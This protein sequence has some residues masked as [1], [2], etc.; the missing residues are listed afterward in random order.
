M[1][2]VFFHI[3]YSPEIDKYISCGFATDTD[4]VSTPWPQNEEIIKRSY[5]GHT[6]NYQTLEEVKNFM[7]GHNSFSFKIRSFR[8][9]D[10]STQTTM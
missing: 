6:R 5:E 10:G 7:N 2:R 8:P 1:L 3:S 4:G 9:G